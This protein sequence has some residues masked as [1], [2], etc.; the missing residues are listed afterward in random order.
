MKARLLALEAAELRRSAER[1]LGEQPLGDAA[2]EV[3]TGRLLH[4]LQVHQVELE[5]QNEELQQARRE[6]QAAL[7]RYT[8]LYDFA[9]LG[10]FTLGRDGGIRQLNL[11]GA[12]LLGAARAQLVG[13]RFGVFVEAGYVVVFNAFMDGLFSRPGKASCE[14]VLIK[15]DDAQGGCHVRIE[16]T[17]NASG[18]AVNAVVSDIT[19]R[20]RQELEL[21]ASRDRLQGLVAEMAAA[22]TAAEQASQDKT[23][24]LSTT[25][26]ELRTPLTNLMVMAQLL[27]GNVEGN[28]TAK[29]VEYARIIEEA[30]NDL[31]HFVDDLL[32]L[33]HVEAGSLSIEM[34]PV[35]FPDLLK[36]VQRTYRAI[37]RQKGLEF[38]AH[39]DADVPPALVTDAVRL[40]QLLRNLLGNAIKFTRHGSV[41]LRVR[42]AVPG[43]RYEQACLEQAATVIAFDVVDTGIGIAPARQ[44]GIFEASAP[45]ANGTTFGL[46]IARRIARLLGGDLAVAGTPGKGTTFTVYLPADPAPAP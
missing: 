17:P 29:Q 26:H 38:G 13:K 1:R 14:L 18:Q 7:E 42:R 39:I 19:E 35:L 4:E 44:A 27:S 36:G 43:T 32:D 10:Y 5:M 2:P 40:Q 11:A 30:G 8:E 21:A 34:K 23:E 22:R 33:A 9:P 31:L 3:D 45:G 46:P 6:T 16:A 28:L 12:T 20:K 37:A 41:T 15:A 25:G 24:F